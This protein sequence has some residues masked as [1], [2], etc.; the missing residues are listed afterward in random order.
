M[1]PL[2]YLML[3]YRPKRSFGQGNIITPVCHSVHRGGVPPNFRGGGCLQ[4]FGGFLQIF[5]GGFLQIFGGSPIFQGGV[6]LIFRGGCLQ[7]WGGFLQIFR[8]V[9]KF[10]GGGVP[11][12][13][14]Q[15]SAG[16]HPTGM[17]SCFCDKFEQVLGHHHPH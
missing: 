4:F 2:V 16:M 3:H 15:R 8:G 10:S 17:H 1:S 11:P 13:Y 6:S 9:S 14:C 5:L 12:E 7:F